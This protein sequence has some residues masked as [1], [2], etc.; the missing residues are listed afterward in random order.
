MNKSLRGSLLLLLTA[1]IWGFSFVAQ[2]TGADAVGAFTFNF[3]RNVVSSIFLGGLVLFLEKKENKPRTSREESRLTWIGGAACGVALFL[4]MTLQQIGVGYTTAGKAG[5]ITALYVVL[6]PIFGLALGHRPAKKIWGCVLLAAYGM[7]L[8]SI[9][10]EEGLRLGL[11]D[12]LVLICAIFY[13]FHILVIGHF[14]PKVDGIRMSAVQFVVAA[15]LS[16]IAMVVKD[17][18]T[19]AGISQAMIGILFAGV[20]S[21]GVGYTLQIVAQKETPPALVSLILSLESFFAVVGGALLL[22]ERMS[23]RELIGCAI[24]FIAIVIAELPS[25]KKE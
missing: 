2:R 7:Y 23:I 24:M 18:V 6:V 3:S 8:L 15:V 10:P 16:G 17:T 13:T 14:S 19:W 21:S 20:L 11:G 4:A 25:R 22:G 12:A 9:R 1:M 5:F